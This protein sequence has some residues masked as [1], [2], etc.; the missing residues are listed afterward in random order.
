MFCWYALDLNKIVELPEFVGVT[1]IVKAL[2]SVLFALNNEEIL[3]T[4]P[5][6]DVTGETVR[7]ILLTFIVIVA[8]PVI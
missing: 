6:E 3:F 1:V 4:K 2:V 7:L 5:D 8:L